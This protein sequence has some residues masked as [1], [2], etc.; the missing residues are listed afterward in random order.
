MFEPIKTFIPTIFENA[1]PQTAAKNHNGWLATA[2]LLTAR[3]DCS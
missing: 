1:R 2:A 3:G